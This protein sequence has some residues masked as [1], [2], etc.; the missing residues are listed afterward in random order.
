LETHT[1]IWADLRIRPCTTD[2]SSQ[3]PSAYRAR[4]VRE[5][6]EIP[7]VV[8]TDAPVAACFQY[9]D[10][11]PAQLEPLQRLRLEHPR[12]PVLMLTVE[13]SEELAVWALRMH[14][15]DYVV[16]PVSRVDLAARLV[17][18]VSA[19][20]MSSAQEGVCGVELPMGAARATP[21]PPNSNGQER[22]LPALTYIEENYSEKVAL[23]VVARLCGIG[24]YQFSRI[25]KRVH[26]RTF[27]EFLIL[28]R[29]NKAI[30]LLARPGA[31]ITNVAF[32]V[33]F[34]DLS[35]FAQMFRRYV[36][37][38]PSDYLEEMKIS[39]R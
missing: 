23:G 15:W 19:N 5:P 11:G 39:R 14:V 2:L 24:R 7:K 37:V 34:N 8:A 35:H 26:G 22:L 9:D 33:G 29:I 20:A 17:L 21:W 16:L 27:R 4:Y 32:A 31:S 10:P 18:L 30:P 6:N 25:F 28:H 12:L 38:C 1:L 13:H 36:G 3:V